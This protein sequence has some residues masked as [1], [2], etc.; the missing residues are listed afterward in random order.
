MRILYLI[1]LDIINHILEVIQKFARSA[2]PSVDFNGCFQY[3]YCAAV[4]AL[5]Y[6]S[7]YIIYDAFLNKAS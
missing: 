7:R 3:F 1:S 4:I 5:K 6:D 2:M